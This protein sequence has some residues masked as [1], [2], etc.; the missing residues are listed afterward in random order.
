MK[1]VDI[2]AIAF[3]VVLIGYLLIRSWRRG[4]E[5]PAWDLDDS[6]R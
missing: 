5:E 2:L 1:P 6:K 3:W 4:G